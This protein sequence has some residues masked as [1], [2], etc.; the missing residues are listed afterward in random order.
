MSER[1]GSG[2]LRVSFGGSG[3]AIY[4]SWSFRVQVSS[5][6][7]FVFIALYTNHA[8]SMTV[9]VVML[10]AVE[11]AVAVRVVHYRVAL[12]EPVALTASIAFELA[13]VL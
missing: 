7:D 10:F 4:V 5:P 3:L 1:K 8:R 12:I 13:R 2:M 9:G 11:F 6:L